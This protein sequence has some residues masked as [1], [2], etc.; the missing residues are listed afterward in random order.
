MENNGRKKHM[1][2]GEVAE[3]KKQEKRSDVR[4]A[5]AQKDNFLTSLLKGLI[6]KEK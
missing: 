6:S 3:I 4:P 1:V 5:G 2:N